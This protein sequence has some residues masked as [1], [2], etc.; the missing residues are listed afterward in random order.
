MS[1]DETPERPA[2][3]PRRA[4]AAAVARQGELRHAVRVSVA[5]GV[6]F[7]LGAMLNFPQGYWM[8]FTAV[9]VVQTSIGGTITAS[10][11]RLIGTLVGGLVGAAAAYVRARTPLEE[12]IVLSAAI[13]LLA[14]GAAVRPSLRVA[15]ITAAIVLVGQGGATHMAPLTMALWRVLEI[16]IGS[17]VGVAATLLIF[18]ARASRT[19]A[20][21]VAS[22]LE[23]LAGQV[24]LYAQ[25]LQG[26]WSDDEDLH[27]A[28]QAS[29]R[30]LA[31]VEQAMT[32][33]ARERA[34]GFSAPAAPDSLFRS[35]SRVRSDSVM[36]GRALAQPLPEPVS[37]RIGLPASA[38]LQAVGADMRKSAEAVRAGREPPA[39]DLDPSRAAFETAVRQAREARMT[40]EMSFDAA[41]QVFG[42]VFALE[43]LLAN[44]ADLHER[45]AETASNAPA[46]A[47]A[48]PAAARAP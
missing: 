26:T 41:A 8:V 31:L 15:P 27:L 23:Q 37:G 22:T 2:G 43:S 13:A 17:I 11:E 14:F 32:E 38:L 28:H 19:V 20:E 25:R 5:V 3:L 10:I 39:G 6:T 47:P 36:I 42:L 45:I 34:S 21:R 35:L 9:I 16:V 18:P 4:L 12:G 48:Q 7:A 30:S 40:S 44:L 46:P 29:R 24:E 33:A 1:A